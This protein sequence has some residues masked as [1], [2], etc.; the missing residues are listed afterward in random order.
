MNIAGSKARLVGVT[1]EI[2]LRWEETKN[3]WKDARSREFDQRYMREL[4]LHVD[5]AVT[6][7]EKLET[8]LKKVRSD[9]E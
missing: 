6:V 1:R 8:I 5:R 7:I 3:Y 9:C 4:G 2:H